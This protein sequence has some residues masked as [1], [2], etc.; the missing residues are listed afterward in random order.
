M[1]TTTQTADRIER[2]LSALRAEVDWLPNRVA[3]W[4]TT[5]ESERVSV[6]LDWDHLLC[7]YLIELDVSYA[8]GDMTE[9][10]QKRYLILLRHLRDAL[11]LFAR[12]GIWPPTIPL[13]AAPL[14]ESVCTPDEIDARIDA[15]TAE[16]SLLPH[17]SRRE[18]KSLDRPE[19]DWRFD[20]QSFAARLR[21][22]ESAARTGVMTVEQRER[23]DALR[24]FLADYLPSLRNHGTDVLSPRMVKSTAAD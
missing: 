1:A 24:A 9:G 18:I 8:V 14:S 2:S 16:T 7:D 11:P 5:S 19:S 15:I 10:Q 6:S 20:W 22:L 12:I 3:E 13:H 4:D 23:Y 17:Q 21:G